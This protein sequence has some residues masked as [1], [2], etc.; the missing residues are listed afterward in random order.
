MWMSGKSAAVITAKTVIA[1][2]L[3]LMAFR[4]LARKR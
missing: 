1:S 3:R 4:H 2:A